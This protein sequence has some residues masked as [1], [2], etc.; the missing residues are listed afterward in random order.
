VLFQ[1]QEMMRA[2]RIVE[3]KAIQHELETYNALL[4]E[5]GGLGATM[6]IELTES[7]R[8]REEMDKFLGVN[9]GRITFLQIG[10]QRIPGEFLLGQ[11]NE[12]RV[13]AVQFVKFGLTPD[14]RRA[15]ADPGTVVEL[16]VD[17]PAYHHRSGIEGAQRQELIRDLGVV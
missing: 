7:S 17:H 14:Q 5:P 3:E 1:I 6:L 15:F 4:A 13:S 8:I 12:T 16:V 9:D 11:S 2:E 10:D